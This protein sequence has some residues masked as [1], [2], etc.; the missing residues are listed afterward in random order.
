MYNSRQTTQ[1]T[2]DNFTIN[3]DESLKAGCS[4]FWVLTETGPNLF[5]SLCVTSTTDGGTVKSLPASQL[6]YQPLQIYYANFTL[7]GSGKLI[8]C[9]LSGKRSN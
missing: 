3:G 9:L 4:V 8:N 5:L 6:S 1:N 7:W 2:D